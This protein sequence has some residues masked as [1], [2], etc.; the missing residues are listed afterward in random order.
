MPKKQY[1]ING[2][3]PAADDMFVRDIFK[4]HNLVVFELVH[5]WATPL[6]LMNSKG[7]QFE[8]RVL[9]LNHS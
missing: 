1:V 4:I 7:K 9:V 8:V 2:Q 5:Y 6:I 3:S